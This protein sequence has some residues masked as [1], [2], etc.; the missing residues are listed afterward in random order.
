MTFARDVRA[1]AWMPLLY[2]G[3]RNVIAAP[4]EM[5]TTA[6]TATT[7]AGRRRLGKRCLGKR[8]LGKQAAQPVASTPD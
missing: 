7:T 4:I 5:A 2:P 8:Y 6:T 1:V 3:D